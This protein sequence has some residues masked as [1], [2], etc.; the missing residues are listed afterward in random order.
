MSRYLAEYA[1]DA[2]SHVRRR[3]RESFTGLP[4]VKQEAWKYTNLAPIEEIDLDAES[5]LPDLPSIDG[6]P[7]VVFVNGLLDES[8]SDEV[9]LVRDLDERLDTIIPADDPIGQLNAAHLRDGACVVARGDLEAI[10]VVHVA[11]RGMSHARTLVI[12]ERGATCTV[13]EDHVT[14]ETPTFVT[15][16]TEILALDGSNVRHMKVLRGN[17]GTHHVATTAIRQGRDSHVSFHASQIGGALSRNTYHAALDGEHGECA[18]DGI[19]ILRDHEHADS[20]LRVAH[21]VPNCQSREVFRAI[22]DDQAR[23]AFTG[24]IYVAQDAQK[25]DGVQT[26]ANLLLSSEARV[27]ARPQLEI[28]ADDVKCTHAA[29]I[30]QIDDEALFYLRA[31]GI[32]EE[33]ARSMLVRAFALESLERVPVEGLRHQLESELAARTALVEA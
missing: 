26:S 13:I 25:T 18:I 15:A 23:S 31:R 21:N 10:H 2:L 4:S 22:V 5:P 24:L 32:G 27:E 14:P 6:V 7:R 8:L 19:T 29:T 1:D 30:G 9:G 17:A 3:G 20:H 28:Y 11:T 33:Q 16:V 12:A